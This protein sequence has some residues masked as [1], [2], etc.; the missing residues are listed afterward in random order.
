VL[1][2]VAPHHHQTPTLA[3]NRKAFRDAQA[4]GAASAIRPIAHVE[5]ISKCFADQPPQDQN[6]HQHRQRYQQETGVPCALRTEK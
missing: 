1:D 5:P 6:Q 2:I 3:I 4:R